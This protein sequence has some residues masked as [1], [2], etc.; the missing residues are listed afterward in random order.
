[1]SWRRLSAVAVV[2][3]VLFGACGQQVTPPQA[4]DPSATP[5]TPTPSDG[6]PDPNPTPSDPTEP[7]VVD[8]PQL[9]RGTG[10]VLEADDGPQLCL[11]GVATSLPPQ[12]GGVPLI[13]WDWS[14][15]GGEESV[16][17]V[18]WGS[19]EVTGYFDG[20]SMEVTAW[21]PPRY[22]ADPGD[23]IEA[24]CSPPGGKWER[25]DP[26]RSDDQDLQATIRK[27]RR[28]PDF[29]GAWID[30][31]DEPTEETDPQDVILSLAFTGNLALHEKDARETWGGPLCVTGA[32]RTLR[33]LRRI[34]REIHGHVG[35]ELGLEILFSSASEYRNV[36]EIGV[37]VLTAEAAD[38]LE[39][40]Y[41]RGTVEADA[42][43]KPVDD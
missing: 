3:L 23:E 40:R 13:G 17:G 8:E 30:Y 34:Q 10:T 26:K 7:P 11:G 41:G 39:Q 12:C 16:S 28:A 33:E 20:S 6:V 32:E 38:E 31:I 18:T 27:A 1:M 2:V 42:A 24:A 37:V 5:V 36:V 15:V 21:G 35:A 9:Y 29:A 43:L 22:E 19:Y 14:E 25:P 4:G